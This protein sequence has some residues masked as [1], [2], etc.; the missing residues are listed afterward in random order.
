[1][2]NTC[3]GEN[4]ETNI[5]IYISRNVRTRRKKA[6]VVRIKHTT[7][8]FH[9]FAELKVINFLTHIIQ[10]INSLYT[11]AMTYI[12]ILLNIILYFKIKFEA[13]SIKDITRKFCNI[14]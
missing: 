6:A 8:N 5:N 3:L 1:M 4:Q 10:N 9:V 11:G 12:N 14:K 7:S 13:I 2:P